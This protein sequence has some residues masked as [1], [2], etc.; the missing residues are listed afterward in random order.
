MAKELLRVEH[1]GMKFNLSKE[2]VDDFREYVIRMLTGKK[3]KKDEFWALKDI[4]FELH[5]GERIGILGLNG[6]GKSTLLKVIAGVFKPTE[7]K[8]VRNGKIVP[9]LELGAGF[10][11]N[12][13][14]REN[15]YLY[16]SVLGYSRK[17]MDEKYNQIVKF[18]GLGEFIDVPIKNYSSGMRSKLGFAIATIA[19]PEIL[20]L[21][22]VLSV[23][24]RKFRRKSERRIL[25]MMENGTAVLFVS[26][27]LAQVQRICNKAMILDHG[28]MIAF[29]DV[30]EIAELYTQM[31]E[32]PNE[33]NS[34]RGDE[35]ELAVTE[36]TGTKAEKT[37]AEK[38]DNV[39]AE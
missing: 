39:T 3:L 16:G 33:T 6:A 37:K 1:V 34:T 13:T 27:S 10:D 21:D 20:I 24:D 36:K 17:Y 23:G 9:L 19:E 30:D 4:N 18:S 11:K 31:T 22:E 12:Y 28:Q 29:G 2:R 32:E 14:G 8:V 26:H 25:K 5:E 38:T 35:D 7:G 15:I